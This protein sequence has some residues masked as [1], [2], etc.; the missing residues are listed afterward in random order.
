MLLFALAHLMVGG[1]LWALNEL[2]RTALWLPGAAGWTPYQLLA[3]SLLVSGVVLL[4][5]AYTAS[6]GPRFMATVRTTATAADG[7]AGT[8][9]RREKE[10]FASKDL[11]LPGG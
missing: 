6:P 9:A 8:F 4:Y 1:F 10:R 3:S 5:L 2:A 7:R 11:L